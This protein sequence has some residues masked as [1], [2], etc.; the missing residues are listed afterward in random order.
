MRTIFGKIFHDGKFF[1][2]MLIDKDDIIT[3]DNEN[4]APDGSEI[5]DYDDSVICPPFADCHIHFFQTGLYLGALDLSD[6]NTKSELLESIVGLSLNDYRIGD[7]VWMWGFDPEDTMPNSEELDSVAQGIPIF[8]RRADGHSCSLSKSAQKMLPPDMRID[9]G[10]YSGAI[11]EKVV[12][13]FLRMVP[14]PEL[15]IAAERVIQTALDVGAMRI[16]ALVPY[17]R[18]AEHLMNIESQFP[19]EIE[20]F[21]ESTDVQS[22]YEL[23]LE[24]IGGCL[25][26]DGS[27]GSHTAALNE[28]YYDKPD[29]RG[30]LYYDDTELLDFFHKAYQKG[31]AV[32]M[33]CI[34]DRAIE[35]YLRCAEMASGGEKLHR[36][37]I[38]HAELITFQQLERV[39]ELGITL[40]V[41]PAF[42]T[43]WGMENG[44]Y[45]KRLGERA[46]YT[47]PI[48]TALDMGI[49]LLG[50][51]DA[52]VLSL[53]H[54]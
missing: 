31:L 8:L 3:M 48:R 14:L 11:Q 41:Q 53:I 44:L 47:N 34:G 7:V 30:M 27:I 42:E 21:I 2:R 6:V 13:Y 43:R 4:Y 52:Y 20:I 38:E 25:L 23:G 45:K 28:P 46:R 39:R 51:S 49:L 12:D 15:T 5:M 19:V 29:S 37:R 24:Q 40:S 54:I 1:R 26:V 17:I 33:H 18:W 10:I 32:V 9:E 36:W 50:G 16:H 35:Q 22:V